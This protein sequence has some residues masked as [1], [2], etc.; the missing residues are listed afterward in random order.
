MK[1]N[2]PFLLCLVFFIISCETVTKTVIDENSIKIIDEKVDFINK[3]T[4]LKTIVVKANAENTI[5]FYFKN[6][7]I[8]QIVESGQPSFGSAFTN[9]YY[10]SKHQLIVVSEWSAISVDEKISENTNNYYFHNQKVIKT[11]GNHTQPPKT[12]ETL[13]SEALRLIKTVKK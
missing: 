6:D 8:Y 12:A 9:R 5:S 13:T 2:F 3:D 10:F 4:S 11:E 1:N 7:S